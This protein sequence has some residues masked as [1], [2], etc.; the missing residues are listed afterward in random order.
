MIFHRMRWVTATS[1][2]S[3]TLCACLGS[4]AAA[5][6][7]TAGVGHCQLTLGVAVHRLHDMTSAYRSTLGS[8]A[9][10]GKLGPWL[11]GAQTGWATSEGTIIGGTTAGNECLPARGSGSLF[12][13]APRFAWFDAA[14]VTMSG[15]FRFHRVGGVLDL[16]G[17][18]RL[19]STHKSP[20][21]SSFTISGS[22][23]FSRATSR[24]CNAESWSGRLTLALAVR[25]S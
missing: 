1:L 20:F 21:A 15:R 23:M 13:Q 11:M 10:T 12:A 9:C 25:T 8:A 17:A 24:S 3:A 18:G 4:S 14:M 2:C 22:G 7:S 19:L 16:T 6:A 5:G